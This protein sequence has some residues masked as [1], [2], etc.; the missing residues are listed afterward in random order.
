MRLS[1]VLG[2]AAVYVGAAGSA[3]YYIK[4][5]TMPP[6]PA[7]TSEGCADSSCAFD[8][9]APHYDKVVGTEEFYMGYGLMRRWMLRQ[10]KGNVLEISAGTG[11]NLPYYNY[12]QLQ[13]LTLVDIT[14]SMLKQAEHKYYEDLN[15][16]YKHSN[17]QVKF[18]LADAE[19][20][21]LQP[22]QSPQQVH[23]HRVVHKHA[24]TQEQQPQSLERADSVKSSSA[25]TSAGKSSLHDTG[26][27]WKFK[28]ARHSSN[29]SSNHSSTHTQSS[30]S[31]DD[32]S[33]QS[34]QS[35][36][37]S[38]SS[39]APN[40]SDT[41]PYSSA[42]NEVASSS[43]NSQPNLVN[44]AWNAVQ[45][46]NRTAHKQEQPTTVA[47]FGSPCPCST[48]EAKVTADSV[49]TGPSSTFPPGSFDVVVDTF[50]LCSCN[51]PVKVLRQASQLVKPG[52]L[53]I[54]LE[55]GRSSYKW[56]NDKLDGSAQQHHRKWGC[57]WNR[58]MLDIVH[59]VGGLELQSQSR[60]HFGTT[61][62]VVARRA[63]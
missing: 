30:N 44:R 55:H 10:A 22:G 58:D 49:S 42:N 34:S 32:S 38:S 40:A 57:W 36:T 39:H 50:G 62:M 23:V 5:Q 47:P 46:G 52:G 14:P 28:R 17:L 63:S 35:S 12:S 59:Q 31:S 37:D 1:L 24:L 21:L 7:A 11:R 4:S 29:D 2:G 54:L 48:S 41:Q 8:T 53:L 33:S 45:R 6:I 60:W 61:Y 26:S 43:T 20:I 3:Y 51:D 27:V 13:S 56:L 25:D 9:C 16:G 18:L 19:N 15:L